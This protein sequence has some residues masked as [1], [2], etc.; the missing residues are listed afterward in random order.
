MRAG[1]PPRRPKRGMVPLKRDGVAEFLLCRCGEEL[2]G[3]VGGAP[4]ITLSSVGRRSASRSPVSHSPVVSSAH[5][6]GNCPRIP[7]KTRRAHTPGGMYARTYSGSRSTPASSSR[8]GTAD[9]PPYVRPVLACHSCRLPP[10]AHR[11]CSV[12]ARATSRCSHRPLLGHEH[13]AVVTAR[14]VTRC[15]RRPPGRRRC[16][17]RWRVHDDRG[18]SAVRRHREDARRRR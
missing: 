12:P 3:S 11:H 10:A 14:R 2:H 9:C 15:S 1:E 17:R 5:N 4:G 6:P 13:S 18:V 8:S 16:P 7:G